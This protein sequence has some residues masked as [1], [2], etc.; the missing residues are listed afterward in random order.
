MYVDTKVF[1]KH[2]VVFL[3]KKWTAPNLHYIWQVMGDICC[4]TIETMEI[5]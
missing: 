5:V 4:K 2:G 3:P 1:I